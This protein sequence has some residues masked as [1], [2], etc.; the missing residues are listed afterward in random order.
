MTLEELHLEKLPAV[1]QVLVEL[2]RL[3]HLPDVDFDDLSRVIEQ[4]PV[5]FAQILQI[6]NSPFYRQWSEVKHIRRLL[7]VLGLDT[8]KQIAV[9]SAIHQ[10][11]SSVSAKESAFVSAI[12]V[13]SLLCAHMAQDLARLTGY[14]SED[15]VYL[16]GL[17]HRIGQLLLLQNFPEKYQ[18]IL[19]M[20]DSDAVI[21][22]V[23]REL[24][25][26]SY[27]DLGAILIRL[28]PLHPFVADAIQYQNLPPSALADGSS[29]VKLINLANR[30]TRSV[31]RAP[32]EVNDELYGLNAALLDE[33]ITNARA[34]VIKL[35]RGFGIDAGPL[36]SHAQPNR[37]GEEMAARQQAQQQLTA[38]VQQAA[39][40]GSTSFAQTGAANQDEALQRIRRDLAIVFGLHDIGFLL[41]DNGG[42]RLMGNADE[43]SPSSFSE[44]AIE[45]GKSP[46]FAVQALS[47]QQ[48]QCTLDWTDKDPV[49]IID[50]QL[51]NLFVAEGM[52]FLPLIVAGRSLGVVA[53]GISAQTWQ[54]LASQRLLL[55]LFSQQLSRFL[56]DVYQACLEQSRKL[57]DQRE[58]QRLEISKIVHEVNNPLA[59]INNYLHV[60][61]LKLGQ[62]HP[63]N[64]EIA[65]IKE[66]IVRVG[67]ILVRMRDSDLPEPPEEGHVSLNRTIHELFKLFENSL[68][69]SQQIKTTLELDEAIPMLTT[70]GGAIKQVVMNLVK[71]AVEA[72]PEGGTLQVLT[73][74]K[75]HKNGALF[76][77]L[78]VCDD[79]P[80]MP[81][82]V[83]SKLF[84]PVASTKPNHSGLGLTIVKNLLD[85]L[86][87]EIFCSSSASSGTRFQILLPRIVERIDTD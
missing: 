31:V 51:R 82:Q 3:C 34:A 37:L 87:A 35:A 85:R 56:D 45:L 52:L 11:F 4:E 73:R 86:S 38:Y 66:E 69:K 64:N 6:A 28:W 7:V 32:A 76:V 78:Q 23:E 15:E 19:F 62:D 79:G 20:D 47:K 9:T 44:I 83:L 12:W 75:I 30:L 53:A 26:V 80:G 41:V 50:Q 43:G 10:V 72:M 25:T 60:L 8:V 17:L 40:V 65:I 61:S 29:L 70:G 18:D 81:E 27:S 67:D 36:L 68:F 84:E 16:A 74:D 13:R 63:V 5:L 39:L 55:S 59:I 24:F 48:P 46:S 71:N 57:D 58:M 2:L 42:Q 54:M 1:P 77:E 49:S 14:P 21:E 22:Q 33:V